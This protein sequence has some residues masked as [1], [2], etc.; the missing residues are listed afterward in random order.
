MNLILLFDEDF[1]DAD[2]VSLS[3]RRLQHVRDIHRAQVGDSLIVGKENG[4][5]GLGHIL[6]LDK[7]HIT[8][9]TEFTSP[10]P[11]PLPL[12]LIMALPR[13][14]VL[15]R[16][17]IAATSMG[18]KNIYL[19]HTNRVEKSFWH[20]PVLGETKIHHS[21]V[22]GL[23]QGK[24]TVFPNVYLR[25]RF[26][27]FVEDELPEIAAETRKIVA[28]PQNAT[29][30]VAERTQPTTLVVGPE[31]GFIPYEIEK[32]QTVGFRNLSL[33]ERILRIETA[34]P[35]LITKLMSQ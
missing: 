8:L 21:L 34:V 11:A 32:L 18:V 4:K 20:S 25:K 14:R 19:L 23:E 16:T 27:P 28:H 2:V 1:V 33:G 12:T 24:D 10:P 6:D 13:P 35:V 30:A 26:R 31:G 9:K 5:I 29:E 17:L 15:N 3:G 22:L 7:N